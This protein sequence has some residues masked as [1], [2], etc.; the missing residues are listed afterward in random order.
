MEELNFIKELCLSKNYSDKISALI[1]LHGILDEIPDGQR[2]RAIDL[3][4]NADICKYLLET[5]TSDFNLMKLTFKVLLFMSENDVFK[6]Y[7]T[8]TM[9]AYIRGCI[10]MV[11]QENINENNI[12]DVLSFLVIIIKRYEF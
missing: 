1:Q 8:T 10:L 7:S 2:L 6:I 12:S 5:I 11:L 3:L 4:I 9:E